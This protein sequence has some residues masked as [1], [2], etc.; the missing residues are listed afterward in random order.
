MKTMS[1]SPTRSSMA[2]ETKREA[3]GYYKTFVESGRFSVNGFEMYY[4]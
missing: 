4:D 2:V 1:K 3:S